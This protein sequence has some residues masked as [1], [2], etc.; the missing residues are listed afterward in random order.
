MTN[1][2]VDVREFPE[3]AA[4]SIEG[5]RH[6][7]LGTLEAASGGWDRAEAVL[8]VCKSGRRAEQGRGMLE[9]LGFTSVRVLEGGVDGWQAAGK[10][11]VRL[12]KRPWSMERQVRVVAGALILIT[13]LLAFAISPWFLLGT[14]FVG[15]GLVFAGV[16]DTC[17]MGSVL[18]RM[19]W[20]RRPARFV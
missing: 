11:L 12:A 19:P 9:A 3:F 4:G 2:I 6:V 16:S 7:P 14:G 15:A 17:M 5:S 13:L 1:W 10:P 18:G 8:L 20:N